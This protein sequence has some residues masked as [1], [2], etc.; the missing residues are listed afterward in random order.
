M[1]KDINADGEFHRATAVSRVAD[2]VWE[3]RFSDDWC[4]GKGLNGGYVMALGARVLSA[5]LPHKDPL[6]VTAYYLARTEPGPVRC[7]VDI[8]RGGSSVSFGNVRMIQSSE[9]KVQ[10][11]GVFTDASKLRGVSRVADPMPDTPGFD[12][13]ADMPRAGNITLRERLLQKATP[14]NVAAMNGTPDNS[15][16]WQ[17]WTAFADGSEIDAFAL[18]MFADSFPPPSFTLHGPVGWV[19]TL[20]L[21]VQIHGRPAP[22]PLRCEFKTALI[23][24][25]IVNEE[26]TLWDSAGQ[27]VAVCRQTAL[28]RQT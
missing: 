18:L 27:V 17:G 21:T 5:A 13:C 14:A 10:L 4:I 22:G 12:A 6:A 11:T 26:G 15:G 24:N 2:D 19:P 23:S 28:L 7:E 16:R 20:E 25:G 1:I 9:L 3:G 8:L